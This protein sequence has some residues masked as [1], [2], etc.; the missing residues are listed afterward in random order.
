ML[1]DASAENALD[2]VLAK[3]NEIGKQDAVAN[4]NKDLIALLGGRLSD[5]EILVQKLRSG[6]TL[7]DAVEDMII[8][9]CLS[10]CSWS[11]SRAGFHRERN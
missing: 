1:A 6:S 10:N 5:L 7:T 11:C 2:Y 9:G 8:R 3:L 4:D